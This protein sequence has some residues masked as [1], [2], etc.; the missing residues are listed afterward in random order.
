VIEVK[1]KI[2]NVIKIIFLV[3]LLLSILVVVFMFLNNK[4]DN[5]NNKKDNNIIK[6]NISKKVIS[7]LKN[8]HENLEY[9]TTNK[10]FTSLVFLN[11]ERFESY[12]IDAYTG[13]HLEFHNLIKKEKLQEYI[14]KENELIN[15]KYPKF[16][17]DV[18][19][20]SEGTKIYYVKD[21]EVIIFFY[22]YR[23]DFEYNETISLRIDYNEIKNYL[24]FSYQLNETYERENGF[25]Y[26]KEKKSIAI[27]F[28]DGPSKKYNPLILEVLKDNKAHATFYMVGTMAVN[29]QKCV[30]DTYNSGNEVGSHTYGHINLKKS[31]IE[32][33]NNSLNRFNDLYNK[34]TGDN[35]KTIRPPYGAYDSENLNNID[36]PLIL[37]NLDTQDWRYRNVEHIVNYIKKNVSDGSI[38]LMHELYETSYESLKIILPWLYSEGYQV[39]S[40]SELAKLKGI[41]LTGN[42]AY[43][44]FK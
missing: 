7:E 21:K 14:N 8:N 2:L 13:E 6:E 26:T 10:D 25:D 33:V 9:E 15:L 18:L 39:V 22:D 28:D 20:N 24:N 32:E 12:I 35:V 16:I 34:I 38:I 36:K 4:N 43:G 11:N 29:C 19:I 44:S 17:A 1:L 5:S 37:W 41:E 40:V 23:F 3:L 30:L 42:K 31:S 27:T